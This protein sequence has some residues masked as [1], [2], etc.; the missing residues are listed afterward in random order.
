MKK[1][2]ILAATGI[3][4]AGMTVPVY[5]QCCGRQQAGNAGCCGKGMQQGRRGQRQGQGCCRGQ[6][7]Q[8]QQQQGNTNPAPASPAK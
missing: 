7:Q 5:G 8:P 3:M 6:Q 4:A 2:M 1:L